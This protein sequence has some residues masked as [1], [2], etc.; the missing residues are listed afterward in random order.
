[1][2]LETNNSD[3]KKKKK[4]KELLLPS[5]HQ[6][7]LPFSFSFFPFF[8]LR[9]P[10]TCSPAQPIIHRRK[11]RRQTATRKLNP[12]KKER[13]NPYRSKQALTALRSYY[14]PHTT[15][16][17]PHKPPPV[18]PHNAATQPPPPSPTNPTNQSGRMTRASYS[19][20]LVRRRNTRVIL[21]DI[22]TGFM[23]YDKLS[24]LNLFFFFFFVVAV[25]YLCML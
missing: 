14:L 2:I 20:S 21:H 10:R 11:S 16:S 18:Y 6:R 8:F 24:K 12:C 13:K 19:L 7:T 4:K 23:T 5:L 17:K 22:Q 3:S 1:M 15:F 25:P 9:Y